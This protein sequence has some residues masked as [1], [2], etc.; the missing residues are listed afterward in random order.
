MREPERLQEII[1][2]MEN[3]PGE[4]NKKDILDYTRIIVMSAL[5]SS[6]ESLKTWTRNIIEPKLN[7]I[8][9][10]QV[11]INTR[12]ENIENLL[13]Q[14]NNEDNDDIDLRQLND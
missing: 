4:L 14:T 13:N 2:K 1:H 11:R 7:Q 9:S 8:I 6:D 5:D 12:L 3:S 10:D